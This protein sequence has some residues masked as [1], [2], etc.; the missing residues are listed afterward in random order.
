[1]AARKHFDELGTSKL[2]AIKSLKSEYAELLTQKK[3]AYTVYRKKKNER[4]QLQTALAN[5]ET[6]LVKESFE[7]WTLQTCN[8][9]HKQ[10]T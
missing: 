1:M 3:T 7:K 6:M 2:P 5:V 8:R 4:D 9:G 10:Y